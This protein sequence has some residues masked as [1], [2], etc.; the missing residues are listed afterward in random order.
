M[1]N[2]ICFFYQSNLV[3]HA[4]MKRMDSFRIQS[5]SLDDKIVTKSWCPE[6]WPPLQKAE[7]TQWCVVAANSK[8][9]AKISPHC[10]IA[11]KEAPHI[12]LQHPQTTSHC[13]CSPETTLLIFPTWQV[14]SQLLHSS[15][16][17][18]LLQ[19]IKYIPEHS[20]N[21]RKNCERA[22]GHLSRVQRSRRCD[23]QTG[24]KAGDW[25]LPQMPRKATSSQLSPRQ[26]RIGNS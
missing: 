5:E 11:R 1:D 7:V 3:H 18:Q 17:L 23:S 20:G 13:A 22:W 8:M 12:L 10:L 24:S 4:P 16:Q 26:D 15:S 25:T 2:P 19:S 14:L 21:M 9:R 6:G